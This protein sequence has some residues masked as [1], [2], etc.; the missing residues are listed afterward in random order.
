MPSLVR[1]Q[2]L[3]LALYLRQIWN[4]IEDEEDVSHCVGQFQSIVCVSYL[5]VLSVLRR[6]QWGMGLFCFWA[7]AK[8]RLVLKDFWEGC[9]KNKQER[10]IETDKSTISTATSPHIMDSPWS[11]IKSK[12][13]KSNFFRQIRWAS[14]GS[15]SLCFLWSCAFRMGFI[16][17]VVFRSRL[18]IFRGIKL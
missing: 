10:K 6:I 2:C 16:H 1:L 15:S 7:T 4:D 3:L 5:I 18:N 17:L 9:R 12:L 8:V 13:D 11:Q 14:F